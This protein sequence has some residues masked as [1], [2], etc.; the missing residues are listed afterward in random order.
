MTVIDVCIPNSI[1]ELLAVRYKS[2]EDW[3]RVNMF[4]VGE[5]KERQSVLRDF[6]GVETGPAG[7]IS[8]LV[9]AVLEREVTT[10]SKAYID[11]NA[12][13]LDEFHRVARELKRLRNGARD[14]ARYFSSLL[15]EGPS[16]PADQRGTY[17]ALLADC[18]FK[19]D[20]FHRE[21]LA[22]R[23]W[24]RTESRHEYYYQTGK[25]LPGETEWRQQKIDEFLSDYDSEEVGGGNDWPGEVDFHFFYGDDVLSEVLE[26]S[27]VE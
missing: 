24:Q 9:N 11:A 25:L 5:G 15:A 18:A 19:F 20:F 12:A 3:N 23:T 6:L 26:Q 8:L 21:L 13:V 7:I 16:V 10:S 17:S 14:S 2:Y 1:H 4:L 22:I 27:M